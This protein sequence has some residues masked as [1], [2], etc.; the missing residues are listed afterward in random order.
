MSNNWLRC[1]WRSWKRIS[2]S[3]ST[4]YRDP[5]ATLCA[6]FNKRVRAF[7]RMCLTCVLDA[8]LD[9]QVE[10]DWQREES[11]GLWSQD[12]RGVNKLKEAESNAKVQG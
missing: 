7:I 2:E 9:K 5:T 1:P 4:L 8:R 11:L 12:Q 10:W 3:L 6:G